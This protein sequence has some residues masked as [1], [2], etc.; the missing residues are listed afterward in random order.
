MNDEKDME[1]FEDMEDDM[2]GSE[3]EEESDF[4]EEGDFAEEDWDSYSD[5]EGGD[6][7][8]NGVDSDLAARRAKFNKMVIGG[9]VLLAL[10]MGGITFLGG[11]KNESA[12][13]VA[14]VAPIMT[15]GAT[16]PGTG[17][18]T[19]DSFGIVYGEKAPVEQENIE[20][21]TPPS[22]LL[23]NPEMFNKLRNSQ[24]TDENL[25]MPAPISQEPDRNGQALMPLPEEEEKVVQN[26]SPT[27]LQNQD[28]I[29]ALPSERTIE[30]DDYQKIQ[31]SFMMQSSE[32]T[33]KLEQILQRLSRIESDMAQIGDLKKDLGA[34]QKR[35]GA[36]ENMPRS[37]AE[38]APAEK[39]QTR[40]SALENRKTSVVKPALPSPAISWILKSAQPGQALV[41]K[42]GES[43]IV[44]I[45]I[46][47]SLAG[48]G[49]I[50]DISLQNGQWVVQGTSGKITQ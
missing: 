7:H 41:S 19:E 6:E 46:G 20:N 15:L 21:K 27:E 32:V 31:Q 42:R 22:S 45:R 9:G 28:F 40:D 43:D 30:E 17:N 38:I 26:E 39:N 8:G 36:I 4:S 33:Q 1:D 25:P 49:K 34:L 37:K 16:D 47:D 29:P 35:I 3:L 24:I 12:V 10:V 2:S 23:H 13:P 44:S 48:I 14:S 18:T 5:E 50:T 11:N